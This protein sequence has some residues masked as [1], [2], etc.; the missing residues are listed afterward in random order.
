[1][2]SFR[3]RRPTL[4]LRIAFLLLFAVFLIYATFFAQ[5]RPHGIADIKEDIAAFGVWA[6]VAAVLLQAVGTVLLIPG[7]AL[8]VGTAL[9]F[10]L[11][12]IWI[13]LLGQTLG[14]VLAYLIARHV[15]R[16]PLHALLG[17]RLIPIEKKLE[18]KGFRYL[19]LLR[20]LSLLPTPFIVYA[21]GLVRL[22]LR[23]VIV[24]AVI[25]QIP[26]V[27]VF[28]FF[29]QSLAQVTGPRDLLDPVFL[30]PLSLL[31]ALVSFPI[32]ALTALQRYRHRR[33]VPPELAPPED[34]ADPTPED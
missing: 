31:F 20:L 34:R 17:Q 23:H 7:F 11:D 30:F 6:P 15:G 10:G 29:G 33:A 21:P 16:E 28:G 4:L 12:S 13:S 8:I 14:T 3:V 1:M 32:L 27:L 25:G 19:L 5:W 18:E 22:R 9:F 2:A 24:A 26:F